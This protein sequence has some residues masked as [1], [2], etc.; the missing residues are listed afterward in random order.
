[1]DKVVRSVG[2]GPVTFAPPPMLTGELE[3]FDPGDA[4]AIVA[5]EAIPAPVRGFVARRLVPDGAHV[6]AGDPLLVLRCG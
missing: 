5:G 3:V 1:M 6:H 4:L 2:D